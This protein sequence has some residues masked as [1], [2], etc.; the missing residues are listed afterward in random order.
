MSE[1]FNALAD[2]YAALVKENTFLE[3]KARYFKQ[4]SEAQQMNF[5][6]QQKKLKALQGN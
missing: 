3:V 2:A 1:E 5:D 6:I 4:V